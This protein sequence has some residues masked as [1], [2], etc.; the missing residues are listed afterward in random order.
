MLVK[1][2]AVAGKYLRL[3]G[4]TYVLPAHVTEGLKGFHTQVWVNDDGVLPEDDLKRGL[5]TTGSVHVFWPTRYK[6]LSKAVLE[7]ETTR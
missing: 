1:R 2:R 3:Y 6:W 4:R 7:E 5:R